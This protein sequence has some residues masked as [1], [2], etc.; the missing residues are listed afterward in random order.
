M[1][2]A[3]ITKIVHV[4]SIRSWT[5]RTPSSIAG[6]PSTATSTGNYSAN[7]A[8]DVYG[9]QSFNKTARCWLSSIG[10]SDSITVRNNDALFAIRM[11]YL[12]SNL[13]CTVRSYLLPYCTNQYSGG[14]ASVGQGGF[15]GSGGARAL[16]PDH[17]STTTDNV[18]DQQNK[19]RSKMLAVAQDV[20]TVRLTMQELD[21][22]ES[23]LRNEEESNASKNSTSD[24]KVSSKS[25]EIKNSIKKLMT[26][27]DFL[28]SLNN[29]EVQGEPAWGLNCEEREMIILA[30]EKVNAC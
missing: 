8:D 6:M 18:F 11:F 30:R 26:S 7:T 13:V 25:M 1:F 29:L 20:Q 23:L 10:G 4:D 2:A 5:I 21:L 28:E 12:Y 17:T 19:E 27:T 22:L 9:S 16:S 24:G 15:Y 14:Q 3:R